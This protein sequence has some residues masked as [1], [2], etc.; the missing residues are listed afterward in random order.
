MQ[1]RKSHID[2]ELAK[3]AVDKLEKAAAGIGRAARNQ[4]YGSAIMLL[5]G[6]RHHIGKIARVV[7]PGTVAIDA[8]QHRA[9]ALG[10][11]RGDNVIGRLKGDIVLGR[12]ASEQDGDVN[13]GDCPLSQRH[14]WAR[15]FT[16]PYYKHR[17]QR[18]RIV[19]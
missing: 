19:S 2:L 8:D 12:D 7:E 4:H 6:T 14:P 11:E 15:L 10:I 17:C 1:D 5:P 13:H 3:L 16:R 9:E 18:W